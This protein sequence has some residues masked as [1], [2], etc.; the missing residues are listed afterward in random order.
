MFRLTQLHFLAGDSMCNYR[1][2][3]EAAVGRR[4]HRLIHSYY[5]RVSN[6]LCRVMWSIVR[7]LSFVQVEGGGRLHLRHQETWLD[8]TKCS[9]SCA[10]T[11]AHSRWLS[12]K[13]VDKSASHL[14]LIKATK[15]SSARQCVCV[16]V[17]VKLC[18]CVA[19]LLCISVSMP[20][21]M[22]YVGGAVG[23]TN[24]WRGLCG[25]SKDLHTHRK[26][27]THTDI[28]N[29]P[30]TALILEVIGKQQ[31]LSPWNVS[32]LNVFPPVNV[33]PCLSQKYSIH[34]RT[35]TVDSMQAPAANRQ[36]D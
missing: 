6:D 3:L 18:I 1:H 13:S 15:S 32:V 23:A 22:I 16:C 11:G 25:W 12:L 19:V 33:F 5:T 21:T 2:R 27:H 31:R 29:W 17:S 28:V 10:E 4:H 30:A 26:T 14:A 34:F 35:V 8:Q 7:L 9:R 36:S 24:F 20:M